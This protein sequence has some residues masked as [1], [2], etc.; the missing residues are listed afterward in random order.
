MAI[1]KC[2]MCGG[3]LVLVENQSVVECEYCGSKQT[4]PAADNEKKLT[5]FA[6]ANRL[7]AACEFDKAAGIYEAIV[8]DFP[9]EAEAYWGLVLCKYGIEYV[10]D[11]ATGKKIPTCHR[12]SF[13]S[14]ME[15]SDFEQALENADSVARRVYREEAKQIE[16][17]R[18]GI[19]AV[20]A[21][22]QPYDIFICYKETDEN[23]DRT[24]DSVLAQDIYDALRSKGYRTF[25]ARISLEDKLGI[26]YEPYIFAALNSAKIMLAVGTDY[27]FY[28]AVWVKNEW[29]RFL[30]LMTRDK[31]KHLIPCFKN[32]D[33]YDMPKEFARLQA[34]DLGKIGA[35]QDLL[36]GIEKLMPRQEK[37]AVA[38]STAMPNASAMVMRGQ[39]ALDDGDFSKATGYFERALDQNP[40]DGSA[41]LGKVLAALQLRSAQEIDE[42]FVKLHDDKD[43]DRAIRFSDP[44]TA[45]LLKEIRERAH[46]KYLV[47]SVTVALKKRSKILYKAELERESSYKAAVREMTMGHF[48][49]AIKVFEALGDYQDARAK[50]Q[51]CREQ[52]EAE[53]EFFESIYQEYSGHLQKASEIEQLLEAAKHLKA[54][55]GYKN[56]KELAEA[57]FAKTKSIKTELRIQRHKQIKPLQQLLWTGDGYILALKSDGTVLMTHDGN[58]GWMDRVTLWKNIKKIHVEENRYVLALS[59][60]GTMV[61]AFRYGPTAQKMKQITYWKDVEDFACCPF[62]DI[63]FGVTRNGML[64]TMGTNE[65]YTEQGLNKSLYYAPGSRYTNLKY[66]AAFCYEVPN[67]YDTK[68]AFAIGVTWDGRLV[69]P[70]TSDLPKYVKEKLDEMKLNRWQKVEAL[71]E[72]IDNIEALFQ[73]GSIQKIYYEHKPLYPESEKPKTGYLDFETREDGLKCRLNEEAQDVA[74]ASGNG[75]CILT[76]GTVT[77]LGGS[78]GIQN[79]MKGWKQIAV[80]YAYDKRDKF[81]VAAVQENGQVLAVWSDNYGANMSVEGWKL[82]ERFDTFEEERKEII[83]KREE[84][85]RKRA[86]Y[87]RVEA[88]NQL[89]NEREQL[90]KERNAL[91]GLF[92]GFRRKEIDLRLERIGVEL[93]TLEKM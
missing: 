62:R 21:N 42:Y 31:S 32:L 9:E 53:L 36:R 19:I 13:D 80:A 23:G 14:I 45:Q 49:D 92:S 84:E 20:S 88:V 34:Q 17:I 83:R 40:Q 66:L 29:S 51:D 44:A 28:N 24:L 76:D 27:E 56:S 54:I 75:F 91:K 1:I 93:D 79:A 11:P 8:A 46:R 43:Y 72:Y 7:R 64:L 69:G 47:K 30:K 71:R 22:E 35:V 78:N 59:W 67:C 68:V 41:Y 77:V 86:E 70:D 74:L 61:G 50:I 6:R 15:D 39:F 60:D 63:C 65:V 58:H 38:V 37:Q 48:A 82:F 3:D 5:L 90:Q 73:D 26:E 16:E 4:V 89:K 87:K 18:K 10:D 52:V 12:S 33:A 57:C 55:E 2:K 81:V 85:E 25:F